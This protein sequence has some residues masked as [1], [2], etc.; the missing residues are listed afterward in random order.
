LAARGA[1]IGQRLF[2]P[3]V[4]GTWRLPALLLILLAA[5]GAFLVLVVATTSWSAPTD[6]QAYWRAAIRFADGGSMY[7]PSA[8]PGDASY[9][10]W[11]PPPLAQALAPLTTLLSLEG[12]SAA[13]TLLLLGCL[14]WLG[15]RNVFVAL[16]LV[17]FLPVA[18]EL[19]V[20]NVHLVLA[21]LAVLALRRSPLFW[22][23]AAAIKVSPVLGLAY[24]AAARRWREAFLTGIVGIAV[25]A[26]S[27]LL[28]PGAWSEFMTLVVSQA[29]S[30]GASVV[31]IPFPVRFAVAAALAVGAGLLAGRYSRDS[32]F[33]VHEALLIIALTIANPTLW[34]TAFSLLVAI[35]P[36]WRTRHEGSSHGSAEQAPAN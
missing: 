19:R 6:E 34:A 17:A 23:P 25:L 1:S 5:I 26:L 31:P 36:L 32:A 21:V 29:A 9:G 14:W 7:D 3:F 11:Y 4:I 27:V 2:S 20:R 15:G 24:L 28:A 18:V 35:V 8:T 30:S 10:Y 16:A 22:I 33:P 13:W 12:F